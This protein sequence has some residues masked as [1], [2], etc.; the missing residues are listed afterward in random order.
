V[1]GLLP[2]IISD[3]VRSRSISVASET[4]GIV[5][6][7]VCILLLVGLDLGRLRG[8]TLPARPMMVAVSAPLAVVAI[9]TI[10]ARA[11]QFLT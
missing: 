4:F 11:A 8:W 6:L 9:L 7:V 2:H 10:A 5:P 3:A 1:T